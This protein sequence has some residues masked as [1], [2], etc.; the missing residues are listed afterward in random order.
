M[1]KCSCPSV[2]TRYDRYDCV[3]HDLEYEIG[4]VTI[5]ALC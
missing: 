3:W 5:C 4:K 1:I 2:S